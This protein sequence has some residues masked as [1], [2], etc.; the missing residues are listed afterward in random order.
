VGLRVR[1]ALFDRIDDRSKIMLGDFVNRPRLPFRHEF[2]ADF[3]LDDLG[4]L[5][6]L[7]LHKFEVALCH[8]Q[9]RMLL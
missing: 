1:A 9:E 7:V 6:A 3:A 8:R 2:L 5:E 4:L